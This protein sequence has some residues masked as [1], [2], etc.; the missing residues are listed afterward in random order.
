MSNK[1]LTTEEKIE[2][3]KEYEDEMTRLQN[4]M[5]TMRAAKKKLDAEIADELEKAEMVTDQAVGK[6]FRSKLDVSLP[7]DKYGEI[8]DFM[9]MHDDCVEFISEVIERHN[10]ELEKAKAENSA[11]TESVPADDN[12]NIEED[13]ETAPADE[14]V[15]SDA[16]SELA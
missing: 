4:K 5:K 15:H 6:K 13:A 11:A 1:K 8:I 12:N 3:S 14:V 2:K 16:G 7:L 9:F 10:L